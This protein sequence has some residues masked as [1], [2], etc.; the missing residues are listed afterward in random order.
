MVCTFFLDSWGWYVAFLISSILAGIT[1]REKWGGVWK[2]VKKN[3]RVS[4]GI[5]FLASGVLIGLP[6]HLSNP[7]GLERVELAVVSAL[8]FASTGIILLF[9]P[10]L[11]KFRKGV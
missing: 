4:I 11:V 7:A 6:I 5:A 10:L 8:P 2:T 3:P 1:W 9:W